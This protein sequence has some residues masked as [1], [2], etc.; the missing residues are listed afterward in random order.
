MHGYFIRELVEDSYEREKDEI[1]LKIRPDN[2]HHFSRNPL[3]NSIQ[4]SCSILV[5]LLPLWPISKI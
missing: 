5:P 1:F 2:Q 3:F 4:Y